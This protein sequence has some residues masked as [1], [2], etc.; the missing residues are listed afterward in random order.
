MLQIK[1]QILKKKSRSVKKKVKYINILY[2]IIE[3]YIFVIL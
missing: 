3:L 2:I 1:T